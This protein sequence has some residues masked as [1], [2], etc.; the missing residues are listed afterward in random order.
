MVLPSYREGLAYFTV[1]VPDGLNVV[2][3]RIVN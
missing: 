1:V 2:T 3:V